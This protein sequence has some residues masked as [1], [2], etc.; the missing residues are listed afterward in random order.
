[1][2]LTWAVVLSSGT[3]ASRSAAPPADRIFPCARSPVDL[4]H[5]AMAAALEA[6]PRG[7]RLVVD[8]RLVADRPVTAGLLRA[9]CERRGL[10][11]DMPPVDRELHTYA[12]CRAVW[13]HEPASAKAEALALHAA[14]YSLAKIREQLERLG[15]PPPGGERWHREQVRRLIISHRTEQT[16][17][18]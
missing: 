16:E 18:P 2:G 15:Y 12:A 14:G 17:H 7:T 10:V 1:M 3:T 5:Q 11:L 9:L 13:A 6:A 4:P 8:V